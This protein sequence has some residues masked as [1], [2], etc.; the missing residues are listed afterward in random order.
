MI[1][2]IRNKVKIKT[3]SVKII[4]VMINDNIYQRFIKKKKN[5]WIMKRTLLHSLLIF[6]NL[7]NLWYFYFSL[8]RQH[9]FT[10]EKIMYKWQRVN[11]GPVAQVLFDCVLW[12]INLC[13]L[14][15]AKWFISIYL[16]IICKWIVYWSNF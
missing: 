14:F 15:N 4:L 12:H 2:I 11:L 16:H 13:G 1:N 10:S 6:F 3:C 5:W 9:Q 7:L 8:T